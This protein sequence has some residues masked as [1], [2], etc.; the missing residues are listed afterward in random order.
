MITSFFKTSKPI[1]Y[2]FFLIILICVFVYQRIIVIDY[3]V[4]LSNTLREISY[5]F[6]VLASFFTLIFIV[7]KNNLTNKNGFAALYFCLFIGLIPSCLGVNSILVSNFFVLLS[8]RRIVSLKTNQNIKKKLLDASI[9][10]CLASLF[11][12][13][14]ILFFLVLF[15]AMVFYSVAHIKNSIIPFCGILVVAILLASYRLLTE[16]VFPNFSEYLPPFSFDTFSFN[17]TILEPESLQFLGIVLFGIMSFIIKTLLKNRLKTPNFFVLILAIFIGFA[18]VF[19]TSNHGQAAYLF[20]IAPSAI[21]LANF[22]E[23]SKYRWISEF[24]VQVLIFMVL[25]QVGLNILVLLN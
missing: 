18:I 14:A 12:P 16:N 25:L 4:N 15:L 2:I 7:T 22:S 10:I 21:V 8:L 11:E 1:Q 17:R 20:A 19:T 6:L 9:W 24:F 23:T 3:E 13:W 5:F